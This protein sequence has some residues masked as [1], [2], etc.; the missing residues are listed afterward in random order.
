M[1]D[2]VI[3]DLD[4]TLIDSAPD[5][6]AVANTVLEQEGA[7]PIDLAE[8]R[9]F[10]GAGTPVFVQRMADARGLAPSRRPGMLERFMPLYERATEL[11][12]PY[13]GVAETL[14]ALSEAGHALGL[15]TNKPED[16]TRRVLSD[17]GLAEFFAATVCGDTLP[18][19]KP[20]PAPLLECEARLGGGPSIYVGDS[21]TDFET[22]RR[23]AMPFALFTEGYRQDPLDDVP[24]AMRFDDFR[25]LPALIAAASQGAHRRGRN[26]HHAS[27]GRAR[28][29]SRSP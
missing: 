19:R 15:C 17:L 11:T 16:P 7:P 13:P 21:E 24:P 18:E 29:T 10:I 6:R 12:R 22:A 2:T 25:A 3:F 28:P 4:G 27:R 14:A 23:A 1:P 20:D 9:S 26:G 8:T 5:I